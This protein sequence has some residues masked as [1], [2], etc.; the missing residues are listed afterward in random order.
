M[1]NLE[2]QKQTSQSQNITGVQKEKIP[3]YDNYIACVLLFRR[4]W[5]LS[6]DQLKAFVNFYVRCFWYVILQ[7]T[8]IPES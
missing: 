4:L 3:I 2:Q 8:D 1:W 6:I 5:A 7:T